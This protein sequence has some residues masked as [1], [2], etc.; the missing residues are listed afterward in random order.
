MIVAG[1]QHC[2]DMR[3]P[4]FNTS[5]KFDTEMNFI[6]FGASSTKNKTTFS[7]H[8]HS[9]MILKNATAKGDPVRGAVLDRR[10]G[11]PGVPRPNPQS[12]RALKAR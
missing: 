8:S 11:K 4:L 5:E 6:F 2:D 10:L 9:G 1:F 3:R 12:T 7:Q